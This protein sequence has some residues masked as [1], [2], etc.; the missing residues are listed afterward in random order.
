MG[1]IPGIQ[2]PDHIQTRQ[3]RI[4]KLAKE[5][6]D[7]VFTSLSH[8][9][10]VSWMYEAFRRT[11]KGGATGVDGQSSKEFE[12]DLMANLKA[13]LDKLKSGNYHAPPVKRI[14]LDK[15]NGKKRPIGIPTFEDKVMQRAVTMVLE[16]LYERDFKNFSYGFRPGRS[17]HDAIAETTQTL[18]KSGGGWVIELDISG[19]FDNIDHKHLREFL[20][21]RVKDGVLRRAIDKWLRAGV[22]EDGEIQNAKV[23]TPQ[24]GVISPLLA[25]IYLHELMDAWF[26]REVVPRIPNARIIRFA[27]DIIM[28]FETL[29]D[30]KRVKAV[31]QKR[32]AKYGLELHPEKTRIVDFRR[33]PIYQRRPDSKGGP[34]TFNFLGF[35]MYWAKGRKGFW[36]L[37][38]KTKKEKLRK[39]LKDISD[40][41]KANRHK[42]VHWQHQKLCKKV[43]GHYAHFARIGNSPMLD[44]Y[45]KGVARIWYRWLSRRAQKRHL[46]KTEFWRRLKRNPLPSPTIIHRG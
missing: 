43:L 45:Q 8:H 40:W 34:G 31:C 2:G 1:T 23:G 11:K 20:D 33:P 28:A 29:S 35:T 24:G 10:D 27:D 12:K 32:F 30:A 42:K 5:N 16:P 36:C 17:P 26:T 7:R 41:C 9:I 14:W 38:A 13:L 39:S 37:K 3:L 4:A 25:N 21:R 19:F 44:K 15:G 6:P 18:W 46:S 22:I